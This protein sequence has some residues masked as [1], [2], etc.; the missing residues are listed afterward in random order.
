MREKVK[1]I[2]G[3][4]FVESVGLSGLF[5]NPLSKVNRIGKNILAATPDGFGPGTAGVVHV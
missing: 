1:E 3:A 4:R 5:R 2:S